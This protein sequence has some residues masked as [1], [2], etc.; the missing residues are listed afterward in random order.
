MNINRI[1]LK[2]IDFNL[3][4]PIYIQSVSD[5]ALK[6]RIKLLEL[7]E[8]LPNYLVVE[9]EPNEEKYWLISGYTEYRAYEMIL[10]KKKDKNISVIE[11][12]YSNITSQRIKLLRKMFHDQASW[13]DKHFLLHKLIEKGLGLL[14]ISRQVGISLTD[15]NSF[16]VNPEL[17]KDIIEKAYK[18]NGSLITLDRIRKLELHF[19]IKSRLYRRAVLPTRNYKR[20]TTE[21]LQKILWLIKLEEFNMLH[22][23]EQM[24]M[25]EQAFIFKEI[26]LKKWQEEC[27]N[28]LLKKGQKIF[29][30][31]NHSENN[32]NNI[33]FN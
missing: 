30:K 17:P 3:I 23:K 2:N 24:E 10:E 9:K 27:N 8:N 21:K 11:Q 7:G 31:Y 33:P 4:V 29:I 32:E 25:V 15:L 12:E 20:L 6:R 18:N 1:S 28:K 22:W 19:L 13:L 26:L 14:E 5:K 16:L